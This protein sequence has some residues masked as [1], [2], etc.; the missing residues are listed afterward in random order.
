MLRA[1]RL[2]RFYLLVTRTSYVVALAYA[3]EYKWE[4]QRSRRRVIELENKVD[5]LERESEI[6]T[7]ESSR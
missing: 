6:S 1:L 7:T 4:L 5:M 3:H 2:I